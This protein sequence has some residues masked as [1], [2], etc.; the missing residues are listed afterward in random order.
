MANPMTSSLT[1]SMAAATGFSVA[2]IYYNQPILG[3]IAEDFGVNA[4]IGIIPSLTLIGY[5][6]G[7]VLLVPL[8]DTVNRRKIILWQSL[9]LFLSLFA[10]AFAPTFGLLVLAS[11]LIGVCATIAQ[12][13]IPFASDLAPDNSRGRIVGL[14]MS[15]LLAGILL[16]RTLSGFVGEV[17]N[18]RFVFGLGSFITVITGSILAFVLPQS[19]SRSDLS[20][21]DLMKSLLVIAKTHQPLRTAIYVQGLLFAGFSA[22]WTTLALLLESP[23]YH[24]GSDIA[25][26]FGIIGVVG[27]LV[28]P[29]AGRIADL[30]GPNGIIGLGILTVLIGFIIMSSVASIPALSIGAIL[31]DAGLM[32][33]MVSHQ[34][35]IFSL[36]PTARSRL[37]TVYMT[38]LFIAGSIGA[39]ASGVAWELKG[40][41]AVTG[42]CISLACIGLLIHVNGVLGLKARD[43][44]GVKS[45]R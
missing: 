45:N 10:A 34:T 13:L 12:Q 11:V 21:I 19:N 8:G 41:T 32:M 44:T 14:M 29:Y 40:W 15:G 43:N 16:A 18:W 17:L 23:P 30:R 20:Y 33:A 31:L 39:A 37:N 1:L 4:S 5:A 35:I 36:D 28:S 42:L 6:I 2:N 25:G 9:G 38:G 22:F 7:L 3:L 26:L 24:L 27:I